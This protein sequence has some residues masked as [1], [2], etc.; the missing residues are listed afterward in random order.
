[1]VNKGIAFKS[2][3]RYDDSI[4]CYDKA[5]SIN[6]ND[7]ELWVHK[8]ACLE[9]KCNYTYKKNTP[10]EKFL[11]K[12][13]GENDMPDIHDILKCYEKALNIN[14]QHAY[15]LYRKG[16]LLHLLKQYKLALRCFERVIEI[17]P[18]NYLA[19]Y[20][21]A[22]VQDEL[23]WKSKTCMSFKKFLGLSP[24]NQE[25]E[26]RIKHALQRIEEMGKEEM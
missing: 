2:I 18:Q 3:E 20:F 4:R 11:A 26:S 25:M 17:E 8:G 14:S 10:E 15:A 13:F 23:G 6:P 7:A 1:M 22:I 12:T 16:I 9:R 21:Q 19:W 24:D 5:L